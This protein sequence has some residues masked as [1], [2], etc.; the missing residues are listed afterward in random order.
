MSVSINDL[1]RG[2]TIDEAKAS[3]YAM[4]DALGVPSTGWKAGAV[5]RTIVALVSVFEAALSQSMALLAKSAFRE[6]SEKTWLTMLCK[7]VYN[8][9]RIEATFASGTVTLTNIKGG[10]YSMGAGDIVVKN[11]ATGK[12]YRSTTDCY[13]DSY[14]TAGSVVTIPFE[15]IESGSA[16]SSAAGTIDEIVTTLVGVTCSN[17]VAFVGSDDELDTALR[18]R[19][20]YRLDALSPAGPQH[21]YDYVALT[22]S[23]TDGSSC[24][25]TRSTTTQTSGNGHVTVTVAGSSGTLTGTIGDLTSNLGQVDYLIQTQVVP[26]TAH[27]VVQS[28]TAAPIDIEYNL[29][30]YSD[31]AMTVAEVDAQVA[32]ALADWITVRPI[33]GD[34]KPGSTDGYIYKGAIEGIVRSVSGYA[35]DVVMINPSADVGLLE[36]ECPVIGTITPHTVLVNR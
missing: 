24:G 36:Y 10:V 18:T 11:S 20:D 5:V 35:F 6:Y 3:N 27:A 23:K 31:A 17:P 2:M 28:A 1:T 15:A 26:K 19:A 16:S 34:K 25:V 14:P 12:T 13:I 30:I 9:D 29:W 21:A 8:V 33:G 4:L 7:Q 22:A 32:T